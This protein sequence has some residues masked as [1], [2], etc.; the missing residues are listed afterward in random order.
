MVLIVRFSRIT[1]QV[2]S[3]NKICSV[4]SLS[5]LFVEIETDDDD[6]DD[7]TTEEESEKR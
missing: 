5:E 1:T 2:K 6:D 4:D 7:D 3:E